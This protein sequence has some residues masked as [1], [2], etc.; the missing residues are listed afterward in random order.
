MFDI[1]IPIIS[2]TCTTL[3]HN[4]VAVI[5]RRRQKNLAIDYKSYNYQVKLSTLSLVERG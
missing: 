4:I 3:S 5:S 2:T 1:N